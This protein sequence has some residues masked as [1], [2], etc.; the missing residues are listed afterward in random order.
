MSFLADLSVFPCQF[1]CMCLYVYVFY[2]ILRCND[3][4]R[5][6]QI[7]T[8]RCRYRVRMYSGYW[9]ITLHATNTNAKTYICRSIESVRNGFWSM[10]ECLVLVLLANGIH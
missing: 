8:H 3:T 7:H 2:A 4:N 9:F 10:V 5:S 1:M 6:V